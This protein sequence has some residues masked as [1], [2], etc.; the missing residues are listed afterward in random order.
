MA[1]SCMID[2]ATFRHAV[3]LVKPFIKVKVKVPVLAMMRIT[4]ER[5]GLMLQGT[6]LDV[7]I[8]HFIPDVQ[9][10]GDIDLCVDARLLQ[11]FL[12]PLDSRAVLSM[13][14]GFNGQERLTLKADGATVH[15]S[16]NFDGIDYQPPSDAANDLPHGF[17][18]PPFFVGSVLDRVAKYQSTEETRYYLNGVCLADEGGSMCAV[19]TDGHRLGHINTGIKARKGMS[20]ILPRVLLKRLSELAYVS[21]GADFRYCA[22]KNYCQI[23]FGHVVITAKLIDGTYP[24]YS[25]VMP[26]NNKLVERVNTRA[27]R[28]ALTALIDA[29]EGGEK[30]KAVKLEKQ[31]KTISLS[32]S[33]HGQ[34]LLC[35]EVKAT[36]K[37]WPNYLGVNAEYLKGIL[38]SQTSAE[39]TI[40]LPSG[41]MAAK[42]EGY[43]DPVII[44]SDGDPLNTVLM[45]MRV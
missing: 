18:F 7:W 31:G 14:Q 41:K 37:K 15:F 28:T 5:G 29:S 24:D 10:D 2:V 6:D 9:Q 11:N 34:D 36:G 1:F 30:T 35:R 38:A 4:S 32:L 44:S 21:I 25:R 33:R 8:K 19:A 16:D 43:S 17:A 22:E 26:Q 42:S 27:L 23:E 45:P 39:T 20:I 13:A 12:A 40:A 3:K